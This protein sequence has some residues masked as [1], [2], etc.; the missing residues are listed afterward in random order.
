MD[1]Q[2][3]QRL[4]IS[5]QVRWL[6]GP[7]LAVMVKSTFACWCECTLHNLK[8]FPQ[9]LQAFA[10]AILRVYIIRRLR[11]CTARWTPV[12]SDISSYG[13]KT[14]L[15]ARERGRH[16]IVRKSWRSPHILPY[17]PCSGRCVTMQRAVRR[18]VG[19]RTQEQN[20][21]QQHDG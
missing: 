10:R 3:E 11:R 8:W 15:P 14:C 21:S 20:I 9:E 17:S 1:Q 7:P 4:N 5:W 12:T 19:A 18:V 13:C 16:R 2:V 6:A